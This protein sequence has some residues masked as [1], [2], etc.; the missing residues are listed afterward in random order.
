[1]VLQEIAKSPSVAYSAA[2]IVMMPLVATDR[3]V[4]AVK[5]MS[6]AASE[7]V[8]SIL[9]LS[10]KPEDEVRGTVKLAEPAVAPA[11]AVKKQP[12]RATPVRLLLISSG[13]PQ[14]IELRPSRAYRRAF[15][16]MVFSTRTNR[17]LGAEKDRAEVEVIL[18]GMTPVTS[19]P[20]AEL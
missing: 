5:S 18:T 13:S 2:S 10:S 8:R 20:P 12:S 7:M 16:V 4:G 15:M 14:V 9:P 3:P 11:V 17:L 6:E 1:M 19:S